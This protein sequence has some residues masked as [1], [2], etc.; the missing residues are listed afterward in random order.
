MTTIQRDLPSDVQDEIV[1]T[2]TK[3]FFI[4]KI[5][6]AGGTQYLSEAQE[7]THEGDDYLTGGVKVNQFRWTPEGG[8]SGSISLLNENNAAA[9]LILNNA[10]DDVMVTIYKCYALTSTTNTTPVISSM[11]VLNG[12]RLTPMDAMLPVVTSKA[13]TEYVPNK[14][15]TVAEGYNWLPPEGTVVQWAGEKYVLQ[16]ID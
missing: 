10:I 13:S 1:E 15:Y 3:P 4:V 8:Q 5:E 7:V 2:H 14:F 9:A 16:G 11:G 6:F 12:S